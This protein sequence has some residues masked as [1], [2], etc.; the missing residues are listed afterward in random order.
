MDMKLIG[1]QIRQYRKIK[2]LTQEELAK[3]SDLSTMSIRR[4][5]SGERIAPQET[6]EKIASALGTTAFA[7]MG[8]EYFDMKYPNQVEEFAEFERFTNFLESIGYSVE[9][10]LVGEEGETYTAILKK[11]STTTEYTKEEFER[12]RGEITKSVDYQVWQ[13]SQEKK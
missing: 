9:F 1:K 11:G 8:A 7:L 12:F 3:A 4:Y 2:G 13:K 6:V 10:V 5:E